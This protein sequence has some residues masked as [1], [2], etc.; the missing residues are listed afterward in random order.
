MIKQKKGTF[1]ITGRQNATT[2]SKQQPEPQKNF[3]L[4]QLLIG[5]KELKKLIFCYKKNSKSKAIFFSAT[6][7]TCH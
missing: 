3:V 5:K 2:Y 6:A 4:L 1:P 7:V